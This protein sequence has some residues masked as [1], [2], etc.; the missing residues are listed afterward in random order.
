M[1]RTQA[2]LAAAAIAAFAAAPM[3]LAKPGNGKG[4]GSDKGNRAAVGKARAG[5]VRTSD[6]IDADAKG[7]IDVATRPGDRSEIRVKGQRL[8][9]G[10]LVDVTIEGDLGEIPLADAI[11][12][13]AEGG[14]HV[15]IRTQKGDALPLDAA[16]LGD[17]AGRRVRLRTD[18]T[19]DLLLVGTIP[20]IGAD[21]PKRLRDRSTLVN[22][23]P[24]GGGGEGRIDV[25]FTGRDVRSD[26]RVRVGGLLEGDVVTF[27]MDDGEGAFVALGDAVSADADGEVAFRARTHHGDAL[28]F[29]AASVLALAG[30]AVQVQVGDAVRLSGNVP[31]PVAE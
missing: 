26:L 25:R 28:P 16:T 21:L 6:G 18:A 29:D 2:A 9:A 17:L 15:K 3:A 22:D 30:R 13:D 27:L 24:D 31:G 7:R 20:E 12:V 1:N 5:M 11:S 19:G 8:D 23:A 14:V 4:N 10:L